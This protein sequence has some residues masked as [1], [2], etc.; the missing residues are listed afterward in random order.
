MLQCQNLGTQADYM[1]EVSRGFPQSSQPK[2]GTS[3]KL[4]VDGKWL[5]FPF[6]ILEAPDPTVGM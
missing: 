3:Q 4:N 1:T 6:R 5:T 2:S